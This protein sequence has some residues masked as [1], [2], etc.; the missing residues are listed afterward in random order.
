MK[1]LIFLIVIL[2]M[3]GCQNEELILDEPM[4]SAMLK[5]ELAITSEKAYPNILPLPNGFQP[6]GIVIGPENNFYVGSI[7]SG[8]IYKGDLR[9]G[10]GDIFIDPSEFGIENAQAVGM[11]LDERS[12]YLFVAAG[13]DIEPPFFGTV[14]IYDYRNGTHVKTYSFNSD[15]PVFIND[16]IVTKNAAFFTDCFSPILFKIPLNKNGQLP[17]DDETIV[18]PMTGFSTIPIG[19]PGFPFPVFGNGID[20]INSGKM[21]I[22]GNLERGELYA[23]DSVTG[24]SSIID[25]GGQYLYYA[26]GILLDGKTLYVVQ[27][28][29]NQ[30]SVVELNDDFHSGSVVKIINSSN[31]RIPST[32]AEF[33]NYLYAVNARFDVAPPTGGLF[34][35]VD[36][37]VVKISK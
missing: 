8:K 3:L 5:Q 6:E 1:N 32:I 31:L 24:D 27:N 29:L 14:Q 10:K 19:L 9:T 4:S 34:P 13:L 26:D 25:L 2:L 36:F 35:D 30:I 28:I 33:G 7:I 23:V 18:L 12:G 20:A 16:V 17:E 22:V 37:E 21:L 11:A 15:Y